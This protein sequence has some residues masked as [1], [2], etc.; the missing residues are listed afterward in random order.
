MMRP[1]GP[2]HALSGAGTAGV[3]VVTVTLKFG[4]PGAALEPGR[5]PVNF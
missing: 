4:V 3:P 1:I 2:W 5:L